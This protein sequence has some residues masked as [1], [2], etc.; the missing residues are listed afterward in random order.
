ME[1]SMKVYAQ[2]PDGWEWIDI[3]DPAPLPKTDMQQLHDDM[4][5]IKQKLG[6]I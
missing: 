2:V 4:E 3:P 6:I 1:D 5:K